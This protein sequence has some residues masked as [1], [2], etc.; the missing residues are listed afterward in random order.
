M[1][2]RST[3]LADAASTFPHVAIADQTA[4]HASIAIGG[5]DVTAGKP[6]A[7]GAIVATTMTNAN[8]VGD[9]SIGT[10]DGD[11]WIVSRI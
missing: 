2:R 8:G 4:L 7:N 11:A 3:T 9:V 6:D 1:F 5:I 10:T